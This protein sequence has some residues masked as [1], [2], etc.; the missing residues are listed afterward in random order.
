VT[1]SIAVGE[2]L[3]GYQFRICNFKLRSQEFPARLP[4]GR[5]FGG[6]SFLQTRTH[7]TIKITTI[8]H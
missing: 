5:V 2:Y 3:N 4:V 7:E 6:W 1:F 8:A